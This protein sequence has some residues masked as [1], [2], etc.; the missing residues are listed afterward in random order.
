M[1]RKI[2]LQL[3]VP[4]LGLCV[5]FL[6]MTLDPTQTGRTTE[7]VELSVIL[8]ESSPDAF[9]AARQGMEQA[10]ADLD[11]ELRVLTL[12]SDNSAEEQRELLGREVDGGAD[13]VVL[14]PT[15]RQTLTAA[16]EK[17]VS[18]VPVVTMET[19]MA[20]AGACVSVDNAALGAALARAAL[21][22][23]GVG[24]RV[25]LIDS[26]PGDTGISERLSAAAGVLEQEQRVVR[27]CAPGAQQ[28]LEDVLPGVL[29]TERPALV[30]AFEPSALETAEKTVQTM[31]SPPLL[32]GMGATSAIAA[33]LEQG[34]ITAI[35]AQNEFAAGYLAVAAAVQA[36]HK[37]PT[38]TVKPLEFSILRREHMYDS[39]SQKLLFPVT[40]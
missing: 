35:A 32:Y 15:D 27:V 23:A 6:L 3:V 31:S 22:G 38:Q 10:A 29:R 33:G 30:I 4:L 11:A 18:R 14:V 37:M 8:R 19:K 1:K 17:A 34:W 13:G 7:T 39:D 20:S 24:D 5:L 16:V 40:R 36:V 21:N 25:L 9:A 28:R 2:L 26:L 12:T